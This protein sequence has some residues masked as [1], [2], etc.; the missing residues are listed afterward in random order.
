[1]F[2]LINVIQATKKGYFGPETDNGLRRVQEQETAH[3][4]HSKSRRHSDEGG[5]DDEGMRKGRSKL[6]RWT[7]HK[8]SSS[9]PVL[10]AHDS[11]ASFADHNH[12]LMVEQGMSKEDD[13]KKTEVAEKL[14]ENIASTV[15]KESAV[16][17]LPQTSEHGH[18][19]HD[20]NG[21]DKHLE[22]VA[23]LKKRSER[24]KLPMPNEKEISRRVESEAS[25][26]MET[27]EVKQ[28]RPAR[29]R[30]WVNN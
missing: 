9:V 23:K 3:Q 12:E 6:E 16:N 30:R 13:F 26:Q 8:D 29:K 15:S 1:M 21:D 27:S 17:T 5:S 24:F 20:A 11:E 4:Q 10:K 2:A 19:D 18:A 28:E 25:V 22:T 7:S 14:E